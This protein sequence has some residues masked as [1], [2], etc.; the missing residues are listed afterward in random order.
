MHRIEDDLKAALRRKPAPPGFAAKV[1]E[2]IE[3]DEFVRKN[4]RRFTRGRLWMFAAAA[5]AVMM[6]SAVVFEYQRYVRNRNEAA[7]Q[8]TMAA[9]SI[10]AIQLDRAE[11][12]A[13]EP[14]RWEQLGRQ[15][16]GLENDDKK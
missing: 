15:L 3:D 11:S 8:H 6:I 10:A 5:A 16:A 12:K 7:L 2:R 4:S 13:F 14:L 9:I 1:L